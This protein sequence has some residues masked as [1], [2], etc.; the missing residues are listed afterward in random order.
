MRHIVLALLLLIGVASAAQIDPQGD[1]LMKNT[2]GEYVEIFSIEA[3]QS[4]LVSFAGAVSLQNGTAVI[5]C[6][7]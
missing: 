3:W 6:H 2:D 1:V 5:G 4:D 7:K